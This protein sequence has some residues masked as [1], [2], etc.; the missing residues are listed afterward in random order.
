M[1]SPP[2]SATPDTPSYVAKGPVDIVKTARSSKQRQRNTGFSSDEERPDQKFH[3]PARAG[4][5]GSNK[6][7]PARVT[8]RALPALRLLLSTLLQTDKTIDYYRPLDSV[9]GTSFLGQG[10]TSIGWVGLLIR[11]A[12]QPDCRFVVAEGLVGASGSAMGRVNRRPD[13]IERSGIRGVHFCRKMRMRVVKWRFRKSRRRC[14]WMVLRR[15]FHV[16]SM[17]AGRCS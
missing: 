17:W 15:D 4:A 2:G 16:A 10:P 3:A 1:E 6:L 8:L 13:R 9:L 5:A 12:A 11:Q 7:P 14:G